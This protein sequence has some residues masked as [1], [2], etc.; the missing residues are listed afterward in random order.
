MTFVWLH[1]YLFNNIFR[2]N[3]TFSFYILMQNIIYLCSKF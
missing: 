2:I 3:Y 1:D